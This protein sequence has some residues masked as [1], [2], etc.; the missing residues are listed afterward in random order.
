MDA[1]K[2]DDF[3]DFVAHRSSALL[4][5]AVLLTGGDRHAGEDLLQNAL[6]KAAGRWDR[7]DEP[8]AYVRRI[9][10]RQQINR[11]QLKW[12]Q[13]ELLVGELP[14]IGVQMEVTSAAE[15]RV[16]VRKALTRLSAR[17]RAMLVLR[18]FE[19]LSEAEVASI[20][21]CSVGTVRSTTYRS[22]A[23]LRTVAP[24]LAAL[25]P[26]GTEQQ[27]PSDHSLVEVGL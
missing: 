4:K 11:W 8:E 22:L 7:I 15:L 24:E 19:D 2:Q 10:Y 16:L 17:Q 5:T 26:T 20:L 9:M 13:R 12:R 18:Y 23:R 14:E 1:K 21:G 6:I 3:R 25:C 27:L